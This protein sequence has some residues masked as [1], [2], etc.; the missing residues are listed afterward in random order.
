MLAIVKSSKGFTLIEIIAIIVIGSIIS[1]MFIPFMGT[2]LMRSSESINIISES[3]QINQVIENLNADYREKVNKDT[4]DMATFYS[5]LSNF[6]ENDVTVSGKYLKFRDSGGILNDS[7]GDGTYDALES[8]TPTG[9]LM[10]TAA[11]NNQ[12]IRVL[13]TE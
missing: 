11:K 1:A 5:N 2:A 7:D 13:F 6:E 12:T 9:I 8:V 10:V 3:F 4:F